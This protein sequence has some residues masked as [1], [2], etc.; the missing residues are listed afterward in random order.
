MINIIMSGALI[1]YL[2][3]LMILI[4]FAC[5]S[6][7]YYVVKPRMGYKELKRLAIVD[8]IYGI[9]ALLAVTFGLVLWLGVGKPAAFYTGNY[10]FYLKIGLF[11]VVGILSIHPTV[12]LLR[13]RKKANVDDI[14]DIPVTVKRS[15]LAEL[16]IMTFIPL[17][18]VLMAMGLGK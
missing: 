5:L 16:I 15:I 2:H 3:L 8:A 12:F 6:I 18:A 9:S 7:E 10:L 17:L 4:V 11:A 13:T 1:K 14:I